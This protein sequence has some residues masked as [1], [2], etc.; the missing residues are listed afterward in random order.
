MMLVRLAWRNIW[1]NKRRS[2]IILISVAVGVVATILMDTL[3]RGM[4]YQMLN[5]QIGSHVSHIQIHR[6]GFKDNPAI[7][8]TIPDADSVEF[9]LAHT[10][11]IAHWSR[12]VL[13]YG[14]IS[15]A[16]S[17]SGVQIVGIDPAHE[18]NVTTIEKS[19]TG[20]RYL[21]GE[22]NEAVIGKA[23]AEKLDVALGD[24]VV[25]MASAIDGHVGS[26]VFRVIGIYET[27]SSEFDKSTIYI[28]RSNAQEMLTLGGRV[29]EFAM[30]LSDLGLLDA[31]QTTLEEQL[32]PRYEVLTY[33]EVLPILVLAIEVTEQSMVI[34]YAII[35]IA[36]IFGIINTMLMA[37][38]ERIHELGVLKAIGMLDRK[39]VAMVLGEAFFL[40]MIG[41]AAGFGLGYLI[42]L[43]LSHS[44]IDLAMFS[45]GLRSFGVGTTIY[46]VLTWGVAADALLVIPFIAVLGA[47]YPAIRAARLGPVEAIRHV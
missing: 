6:L 35:G 18:R 11:G 26:D 29:S 36:L 4:V 15:S 8:S 9:V 34:F 1:R 20:G 2:V 21:S 40:G 17:S 24:R 22:P 31:T 13:T 28:S 30:V 14:L 16:T 45:E 10:N 12:R 38:F 46:P 39:L 43:P 37:I 19:L 25:A 3:S 41:T 33:A 7:Q 5:N 47:V 44:G 27:V 42:Y 32:G 23:L